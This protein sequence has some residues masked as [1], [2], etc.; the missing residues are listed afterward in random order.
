MKTSVV[1]ILPLVLLLA[2]AQP[3]FAATDPQRVKVGV[4]SLRVT[5]QEFDESQPWNK[6]PERVTAGSALVLREK[7]LLTT[8]DM[9]R[10]A[11]LIEVRKRGR[12]PNYQAEAV[13]V[14]YEV[15]LAL[16]KVDAPGFWR[17]LTPLP[18]SGTPARSG[19]FEINRWRNGG[20]FEQGT[21][22][23]VEI[24]VA[25]SRF[26]TLDL[27]LLRG[28]TGMTGLG[29]AEVLTLN[30]AVIGIVTGHGEQGLHAAPGPVLRRFIAGLKQDGSIGFAHRGFTWQR[31]NQTAMRRSFGLTGNSAGVLVRRVYGGGTGA[32]M[33]EEGDILIRI[34]ENT[35]DPEGQID[36]SLYGQ[37]LFTIALNDT[38]EKT[39]PATVIRN[40]K[41][42]EIQLHRAQFGAEDYRIHPYEFD[43]PAD[44]EVFGGL[45][46]QE[47]S[48][49]YLRQWG[50]DWQ[51][52]APAR[53]VI[54]YALNALRGKGETN[55]KV[56][57]V[58]KVLSDPV[59]L[60]YEEVTNAILVRVNG[61]TPAS[62][63]EFRSALRRPS[64][65]FHTIEIKP[66]QGRGTLVFAAEEIE[67]A[68]R[69]IRQ[70]YGVS[71]SVRQVSGR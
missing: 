12:Y 17:D 42:M 41:L 36:H 30:G 26:G 1:A 16:L 62:L 45:V 7:L 64:N 21:G 58:T 60:G 52:K 63:D 13:V 46:V 70:I 31:L 43:R 3:A 27:P 48:L 28:S 34:G 49:D 11:T 55:E 29:W 5:V 38:L 57:I 69:R 8:A 66:G 14:N 40:G 47:L 23:L 18:I 4:V 65:G 24:R 2:G 68:N 25:T 6:R 71:P 32:E 53:L 39:T 19:R 44:F 56:L 54:E 10:N 67:E 37:I 20:R 61:R 59:N 9:V 33:L 35:I 15:D 50:A 22:E 51:K